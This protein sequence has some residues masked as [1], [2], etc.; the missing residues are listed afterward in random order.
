MPLILSYLKERSA[1]LNWC[2][3]TCCLYISRINLIYLP[4]IRQQLKAHPEFLT[5][6]KNGKSTTVRPFKRFN[7]ITKPALQH[8]LDLGPNATHSLKDLTAKLAWLISMAG[9]FRPSDLARVDIDKTTITTGDIIH[10]VVVG[11]KEKHRGQPIWRS[12][13]IHPRDNPLL[14]PVTIIK[15]Y[16]T[17]AAS[18]PCITPHSHLE[19][20]STN[21]LVRSIVSPSPPF[22]LVRISKYVQSIMEHVD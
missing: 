12:V 17:R 9:F 5:Y 6:V 18:S 7:Y 11:P 19:H 22:S 8:L 3:T 1:E 13:A 21:A 2:F 4:E 20:T 14:C 15:D 16:C 10:L